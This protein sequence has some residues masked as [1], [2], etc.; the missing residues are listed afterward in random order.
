MKNK[1]LIRQLGALALLL[2]FSFSIMPKRYLHEVLADHE[3]VVSEFTG[4]STTV[5]TTGMNCHYDDL[6]VTVPF[7]EGTSVQLSAIE[8]V[9]SSYTAFYLPEV[10]CSSLPAR[11][12]RGP[13]VV[14]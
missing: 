5:K 6:V 4:K 7:I 3:D 13:P 9:P 11:D 1:N 12:T 2:L 8:P 14:C 10:I